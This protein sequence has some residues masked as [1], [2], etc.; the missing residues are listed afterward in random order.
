MAIT[1]TSYNLQGWKNGENLINELQSLSDVILIQEH[2]LY[3][4]TMHKL[5]DAGDMHTVFA[6]S[7]MNDDE[8]HSGRPYGGLAILVNN[9]LLSFCKYF[10]H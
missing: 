9:K 4:S 2:W 7:S 1:L 3:P 5:K 6:T 10:G 8:I